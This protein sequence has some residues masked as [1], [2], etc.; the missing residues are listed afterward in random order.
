MLR[1]RN[2]AIMVVVFAFSQSTHFA[3]GSG[4][5]GSPDQSHGPDVVVSD[6]SGPD[7]F[8]VSVTRE[9]LTFGTD[10]CNMGDEE[11]LWEDCP[12]TTHPVFGGN[13]YKWYKVNGATRF[14]QIGQSWLKHSLGNTL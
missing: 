12:A 6:L 9:A 5:P 3:Y 7:N 1:N 2:I 10:A 14:E 8:S 4:C 11:V 13:L